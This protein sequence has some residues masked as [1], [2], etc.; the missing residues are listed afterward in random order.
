[1]RAGSSA[2]NSHS[3]IYT[4]HLQIHQVINSL[5]PSMLLL[6]DLFHHFLHYILLSLLESSG[7]Q[8]KLG[9]AEIA[10]GGAGAYGGTG[11]DANVIAAGGTGQGASKAVQASPISRLSL[12]GLFDSSHPV[13]HFLL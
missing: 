8:A 6:L 2:G 1:M 3:F 11:S 12:H 10:A 7:G 9:A 5:P 4:R 13:Q